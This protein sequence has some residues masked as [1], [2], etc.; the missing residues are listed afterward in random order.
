MG[1]IRPELG[2]DAV[3]DMPAGRRG[4]TVEMLSSGAEKSLLMTLR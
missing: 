1:R 2:G 3:A 4:S